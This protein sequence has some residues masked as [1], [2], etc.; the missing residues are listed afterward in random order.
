MKS[1]SKTSVSKKKDVVRFILTILFLLL[2]S[3]GSFYAFK[4]LGI[5][6]ENATSLVALIVYPV[7]GLTILLGGFNL[8]GLDSTDKRIMGMLIC[9]A[10]FVRPAV[11]L[12]LWLLGTSQKVASTISIGA[13]LVAMLAMIFGVYGKFRRN[14]L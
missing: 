9:L 13:W 7:F 3:L 12:G 2:T 4:R 5:Q 8:F 11:S 6:D 1:I 10:F 14:R